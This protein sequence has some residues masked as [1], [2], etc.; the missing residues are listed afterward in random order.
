MT[1][2]SDI[3]EREEGRLKRAA[4]MTLFG[5]MAGHALLE[6]ARDALFLTNVPAERLPWVY[7]L[8]A[9]LAVFIARVQARSRAAANPRQQLIGAYAGSR[10]REC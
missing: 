2:Q 9:L 8:I 3:S 6:T 10:A 5:L 1:D 7:L 4:F